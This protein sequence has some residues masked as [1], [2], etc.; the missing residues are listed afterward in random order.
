MVTIH[1]GS[2]GHDHT[3]MGEED[4]Q[5]IQEEGQ[6]AEGVE[7]NGGPV[8]SVHPSSQHGQRRRHGVR[9]N[10]GMPLQIPPTRAALWVECKRGVLDRRLTGSLKHILREFFPG[11]RVRPR[12]KPA[13]LQKLEASSRCVLQVT[14]CCHVI[15]YTCMCLYVPNGPVNHY[16]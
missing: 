7:A 14:I 12:T 16:S 11:E 13:L 10:R 6:H 2:A 5:P 9:I 8:H 4:Q 1:D 15:C 3:S